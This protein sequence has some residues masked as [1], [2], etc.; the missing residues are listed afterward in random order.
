[1]RVRRIVLDLSDVADLDHLNRMLAD[2]L[3]F[4]AWYGKNW[5]AFHDAITGLV[6]MPE[7]LEIA[8]W[9]SFERRFPR[10]AAIMKGCLDS[11]SRQLPMLA[12]RVVY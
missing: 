1:M 8:G 6:D 11:M 4:P 9:P 2:A 7:H 12:A 3:G 5:D 10:D